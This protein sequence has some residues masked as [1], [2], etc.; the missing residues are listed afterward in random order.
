MPSDGGSLGHGYDSFLTPAEITEIEELLAHL[1]FDPGR[2]DGVIDG[3]MR[4]AT[5]R[6]Q[7]FAGLPVDGIPSEAILVDLRAVAALIGG[8]G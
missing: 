3:G 5:R 2:I 6:Y 1:K 4:I 8:G 7:E